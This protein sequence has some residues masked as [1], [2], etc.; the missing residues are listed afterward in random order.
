MSAPRITPVLS[1]SNSKEPHL[2]K[3]IRKRLT[4]ANVM[5]S[6]A[7]FLVLGGAAFAAAQLPKN[8]VGSKQLKKNAVTAAKVKNGAIV[9]A[10]IGSGAV[11][12]SKLANDAA[13]GDKVLESSLSQVPSA[14]KANE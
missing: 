6:I 1:S 10:K 8:S 13:T 12:T 2:V 14:A 3:Q 9:E 7:V 5:S 11:T 4:Y